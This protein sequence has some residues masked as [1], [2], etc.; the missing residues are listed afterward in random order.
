MNKK[1]YKSWAW[2]ILD[3]FF[4]IVIHSLPRFLIK[5]F[6]FDFK[7]QYFYASN[8]AMLCTQDDL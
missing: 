6:W 2:T 1:I 4:N 7:S 3:N 5:I 8:L